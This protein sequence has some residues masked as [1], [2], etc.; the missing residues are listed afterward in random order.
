MDVSVD[1]VCKGLVCFGENL[2]IPNPRKIMT[3]LEALR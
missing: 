2:T 1:F 3:A